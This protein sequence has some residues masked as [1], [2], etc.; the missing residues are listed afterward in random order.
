MFSPSPPPSSH[1]WKNDRKTRNSNVWIQ[2]REAFWPNSLSPSSWTA[3]LTSSPS[4]LLPPPPSPPSL[5]LPPF[6][7]HPHTSPPYPP[8]LLNHRSEPP[9]LLR[10]GVPW[11][12][13]IARD[14]M[15][16]AQSAGNRELW[17]HRVQVK[18]DILTPLVKNRVVE[19]STGSAHGAGIAGRT[20]AFTA[21]H[22]V[23]MDSLGNY[24]ARSTTSNLT[25]CKHRR[26][27]TL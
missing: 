7:S 24:V 21:R 8:L 18:E 20:S 3:T 25:N 6:P 5:H 22:S 11:R 15:C 14:T 1:K 9:L 10:G 13:H 17:D 19:A 26:C 12:L 16:K 23:Q 2:K 27:P 4:S